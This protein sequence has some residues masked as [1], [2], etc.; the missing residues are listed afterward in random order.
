MDRRDAAAVRR[1]R[2]RTRGLAVLIRIAPCRRS[3]TLE[4]VGPALLE[5][6]GAVV[7]PVWRHDTMTLHYPKRCSKCGATKPTSKFQRDKTHKDGFRS[8]CRAC[9]LGHDEPP[10]PAS[11]RFWKHVLVVDGDGCWEWLAS[12]DV[13][14][15][16]AFTCEGKS[17]KAHRFSWVMENGPIPEGLVVCHRCDNPGCVRPSHMFIGTVADNNH[18]RDAKGRTAR[19][20]TCEPA[21]RPRGS[22]CGTAKLTE[23][24]VVEIRRLGSARMKR[25]AIADM[26]NV[27]I[28][29]IE[30]VLA[31]TCW[32]HV[33]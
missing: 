22:R 13:G 10:D 8:R 5:A 17:W 14:G 19:G 30:R 7:E 20:D 4:S 1:K 9:T 3:G 25:Q 12:K 27:S 29:T 23:Q 28:A 18:D 15:Y 2:H 32:K 16:G 26:F 6:A 33:V 11:F 31:R 21:L 24:Q